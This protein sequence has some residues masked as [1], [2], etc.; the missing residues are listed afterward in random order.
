MWQMCHWRPRES[1]V[2]N[3]KPEN[4]IIMN[5]NI[6]FSAL[7]QS[8]GI[9][10]FAVGL[11]C[12]CAT[13]IPSE[14]SR[15]IQIGGMHETIGMRQHQAR[16]AVAEIASEPHFYGVGALE[17]LKGEITFLDSEPVITCVTPNGA[18]QPVAA[19]DAQATLIVGQSV[20]GWTHHPLAET[21]AFAKFDETI[22]ERADAAG[23]AMSDPFFFVIEGA[24]TDVRIHVING[25]CPIHARMNKLEIAEE[26]QPFELDVESVSGT[27][28]GVYA[29][30]SVGT[31]THPAQKTHTHLI[32]I[33]PA[34]GDR[35]TGH[36]ERVGLTKGA[37]LKLPAMMNHRD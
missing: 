37:V 22:G 14:Q 31:L 24:F 35:V 27:L 32:Y 36:V 25:A 2:S 17:G 7:W 34:T 23:L 10:F 11:L 1:T 4:R 18:P 21:V 6:N 13:S 3:A 29:A 15:L 9:C 30:D 33:D 20:E 12:S 5:R 19:A 26:E 28:V 16:V 8:I